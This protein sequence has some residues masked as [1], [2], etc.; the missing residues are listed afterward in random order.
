MRTKHSVRAVA[1]PT[2]GVAVSPRTPWR[3][4]E[5][6]ADRNRRLSNLA[7][8]GPAGVGSVCPTCVYGKLGV[9]H[10]TESWRK[11]DTQERGV[12]G[13]TCALSGRRL[14]KTVSLAQACRCVP[15]LPSSTQ[16]SDLERRAA[17]RS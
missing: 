1:L 4:M 13:G 8:K 11:V 5:A 9:L 10:I 14:G 12:A 7:A 6:N 3:C 15:S 2:L 16:A 17:E